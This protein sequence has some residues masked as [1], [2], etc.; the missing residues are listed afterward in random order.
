MGKRRQSLKRQNLLTAAGH[1]AIEAG[2]DQLTLDAVARRAGVSKGGLLYHF[3][4]KNALLTAMIEES[5][6]TFADRVTEIEN[7]LERGSGRWLH[8]FV[9]AS[10]EDDELPPGMLAAIVAHAAYRPQLL[11]PV[12]TQTQEWLE[13][14]TRDGADS[15]TAQ[16]VIA[17]TNGAWLERI[18]W[19]DAAQDLLR[20]R[21]HRLIDARLRSKTLD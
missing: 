15:E 10:F 14:A 4:T 2:A 1:L 13:A 16:I 7:T 11:D 17:A 18:F 9:T 3:P 20:E 12:R 21:L 19:R 8:A 6:A 5:N